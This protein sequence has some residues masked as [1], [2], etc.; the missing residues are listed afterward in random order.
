MIYETFSLDYL[1]AILPLVQEVSK[2]P[3]CGVLYLGVGLSSEFIIIKN[4]DMLA[5]L[6]LLW[7]HGLRI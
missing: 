3:S 2:I 7:L 1:K 4:I 6:L 5:F